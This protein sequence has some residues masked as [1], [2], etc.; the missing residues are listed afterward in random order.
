GLQWPGMR[1]GPT[2]ALALIAAVL[3]GAAV[4]AVAGAAGRLHTGGT[5]TVV[6]RE[7][8][9]EAAPVVAA[10]PLVGNGFQPAQIYRRRA[11]GVV[12]II[13]FFSSPDGSAG[14]GSGFVVSRRGVI[15]TSAHVITTAGDGSSGSVSAAH[16]IYVEFA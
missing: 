14:Q 13:S 7:P 2:A 1:A 3:G 9:G 16:H 15:L 12:T 8:A 6:V 5:N 4:L 10:R 11:A